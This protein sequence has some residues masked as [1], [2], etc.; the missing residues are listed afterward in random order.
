MRNIQDNESKRDHT[1]EATAQSKPLGKRGSEVPTLCSGT[2]RWWGSYKLPGRSPPTHAFLLSLHNRQP[3]ASH[4]QTGAETEGSGTR[5]SQLPGWLA[6]PKSAKPH[7]PPGSA[8]AGGSR[9]SRATSNKT[10]SP[11]N[12]GELPR[13][14][15]RTS[16]SK[17]MYITQGH[18]VGYGK[19]E[20]FKKEICQRKYHK[21]VK[22]EQALNKVTYP[23]TE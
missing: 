18:N 14:R 13:T 7:T 11:G 17:K 2:Q 23:M 16:R 3:R 5:G 21:S 22:L 8:V 6:V 10:V 19:Q 12:W 20:T 4:L 15:T 1:G 9:A